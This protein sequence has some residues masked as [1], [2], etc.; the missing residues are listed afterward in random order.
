MR[1]GANI[2]VEIRPG[3]AKRTRQSC[4]TPAMIV[5][6]PHETSRN[7][8]APTRKLNVVANGCQIVSRARQQPNAT[9]LSTLHPALTKSFIDHGVDV[10][11][12][13]APATLD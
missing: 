12:R 7:T 13:I 5:E 9:H 10:I 11:G 2:R 3:P 8:A 1:Y 4:E 6:F